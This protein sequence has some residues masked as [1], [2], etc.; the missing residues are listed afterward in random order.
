MAVSPTSGVMGL[1]AYQSLK[2]KDGSILRPH[3][4]MFH[5]P[6]SICWG[7][8]II[9]VICV[10]CS[11]GKQ[12]TLIV[13]MIKICFNK[14]KALSHPFTRLRRS[15]FLAPCSIFSGNADDADRHDGLGFIQNKALSHRP[16]DFHVP[17]SLFDIPH[18]SSSSLNPSPALMPLSVCCSRQHSME[19][20]C[21]KK[22]V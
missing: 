21:S 1:A 16:P 20:S 15:I 14:T 3:H 7:I 11:A 19:G 2:I 10:R 18:P 12:M 9:S 17:Y 13:M 8:I 22:S 4:P 6:C 5:I